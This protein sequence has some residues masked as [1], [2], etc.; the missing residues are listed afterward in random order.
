VLQEIVQGCDTVL[1]AF[2]DGSCLISVGINVVTAKIKAEYDAKIKQTS[3][4]VIPVSIIKANSSTVTGGFLAIIGEPSCTACCTKYRCIVNQLRQ[5]NV[6]SMWNP[7]SWANA[8]IKSLNDWMKV[9]H[10][11]ITYVN[12][13]KA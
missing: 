5:L 8:P 9:T 6:A 3:L 12:I 2:P 11:F 1:P 7:E 10:S 4:R 13:K